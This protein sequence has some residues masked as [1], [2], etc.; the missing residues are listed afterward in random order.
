M[1]GSPPPR[2][3]EQNSINYLE[4]KMSTND[5]DFTFWASKQNKLFTE[6]GPLV[7][8]MEHARP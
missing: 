6:S 7:T 5:S 8:L 2:E 1:L 3:A 4:K